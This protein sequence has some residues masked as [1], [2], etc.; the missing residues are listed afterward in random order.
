MLTNRKNYQYAYTWETMRHIYYKNNGNNPM[1]K[2]CLTL[3]KEYEK[4]AKKQLEPS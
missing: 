2:Y 1:A 3:A 4:K